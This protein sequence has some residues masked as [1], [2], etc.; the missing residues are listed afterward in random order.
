[1][2]SELPTDH[3][4]G[5]DGSEEALR[6]A[7]RYPYATPPV[8][9]VLAGG[10]VTEVDWRT[11]EP[12]SGEPLLAY[13]ANACPDVL[14]RK[15]GALNESVPARRCSLLGFDVVYS[16]HISPYGAVPATLIPSPGTEV[17]AFVLYLSAAQR[18]AIT[19]T[20]PNYELT[21][22]AALECRFDDG[23]R[24]REPPAYLSRHGC[25]QLDG[26]VLA[27]SAVPATGRRFA[28]IGEAEVLERLRSM[29]A[30]EQSL[31]RFVLAACLD[32][33]LAQER[34]RLLRRS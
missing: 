31:A 15:L 13:G 29:L 33:A 16:A 5:M 8:S 22:V 23:G 1:M 25:L 9:F 28:A 20:E 10:R 34:T 19:A 26:A 17:S 14:W 6:R 4:L 27:L 32:P 30:P 24:L 18:R 12:P 11:A 3:P 7:I 21:S 2:A